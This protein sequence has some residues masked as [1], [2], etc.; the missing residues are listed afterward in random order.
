MD[1][2]TRIAREQ[3]PKVKKDWNTVQV[4]QYGKLVYD[5]TSPALANNYI[6]K[7]NLKNC[8]KL[9]VNI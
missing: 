9:F 1:R 4:W 8:F 5:G 2:L 6:K 7:H 3:K